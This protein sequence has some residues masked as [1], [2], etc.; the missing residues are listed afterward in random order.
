MGE[1][2]AAV[3]YEIQTVTM[4][5]FNKT[6]KLS[7]KLLGFCVGKWK[8]MVF[9]QCTH[10]NFKIKLHKFVLISLLFYVKLV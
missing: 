6:F 10:N 4:I 5:N 3:Q 9:L 7:L 8:K 2:Y 1:N